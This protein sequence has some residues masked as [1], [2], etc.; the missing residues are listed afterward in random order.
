MGK[1]QRTVGGQS[2]LPS[3]CV[4]YRKRHVDYRNERDFGVF[5]AQA[6]ADEKVASMLS[7]SLGIINQA[8]HTFSIT[9]FEP[10]G[11]QPHHLAGL[12]D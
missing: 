6:F 7:L 8:V 1:S 3:A 10:T 12:V 4:A 11:N 5:I 9:R 2:V